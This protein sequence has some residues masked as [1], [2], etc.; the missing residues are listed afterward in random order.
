MNNEKVSIRR[1]INAGLTTSACNF[2]CGYCYISQI[3]DSQS[4]RMP[5]FRY[6]PE[7]IGKALS[8]E[9]LGGP[10]LFNLCA[11]GETL[12]P[13]EMPSILFQILQQGHYVE[14]VTN[15]VIQ[16][17]FDEI[18]DFPSD[19]LSRLCFKFSFHFNELK[20]R[21]LLNVFAQNVQRAKEKGCSFTIE[22]VAADEFIP[23]I[24]E[25]KAFCMDS[26]GALCHLT[27]ARDHSNNLQ[28]LSSLSREEYIATWAS[29][30]SEMF[31]FKMS[32]FGEKRTEYCYAGEWLID[33]D[34][35][36]GNTTQCYC[37]RLNQNIYE[38]IDHPIHFLPIGRHCTLEHCYNAHALM[39]LGMIPDYPTPTYLQMRNRKCQDGTSWFSP[40][41][42][43]IYSTKLFETN[44]VH[45]LPKRILLGTTVNAMR[46][47]NK[48]MRFGKKQLFRGGD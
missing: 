22:L 3:E 23:H 1:M 31:N 41:M 8:V 35:E 34:I 24:E 32:V 15:G 26:F 42:K 19:V 45:S 40:Q 2:R 18:F 47:K 10:C 44:N 37:S 25:I 36:T 6:S 14:L 28:L 48:I 13:K 5:K 43:Q 9:R 11:N 46:A 30:D 29:F 20:K 38:N 33:V 4:T 17:R 27:V 39:T 16:Q 21:G 7:F 12:L